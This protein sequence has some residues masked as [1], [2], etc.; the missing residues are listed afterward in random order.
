MLGDP[1]PSDN[2]IAVSF[3]QEANA[4]EALS[5]LKELDSKGEIGVHEAAVV[6]RQEDGKIVE[7]DQFD[8]E[9]SAGT[10]GGGLIGLLIGVL[11]GPLGVLVGGATGVLVGSLFDDDDADETESALGDM[12]KSIRVGPPGLLAHVSEA[13]P[14]AIDAVMANL[15]GTVFRRSALDVEAEIAAAQDAQREAKR[16]ARQELRDARHKK[17]TEEIDAKLA[18]LKA[19]LHGHKEPAAAG[20]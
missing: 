16:K 8:Q 10:A 20:S 1:D 17:Q 14:A 18:Q 15:G 9:S 5:R 19:K 11:G 2:V 6:S 13:N 12:S 3:E 4:Y 7:K